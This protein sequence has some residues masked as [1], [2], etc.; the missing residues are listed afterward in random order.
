MQTLVIEIITKTAPN[1]S[2]E[3]KVASSEKN[4]CAYKNIRYYLQNKSMKLRTMNLPMRGGQV[5]NQ[6]SDGYVVGKSKC[7]RD[8]IDDTEKE[9]ETS[10][11]E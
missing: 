11:M 7:D 1:L 6:G 5:D 2:N 9:V 3:L 10:L 4:V 8:I